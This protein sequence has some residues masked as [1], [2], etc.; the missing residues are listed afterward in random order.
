MCKLDFN[1]LAKKV[2]LNDSIIDPIVKSILFK[3]QLEN[4]ALAREQKKA[5]KENIANHIPATFKD[6]SECSV[7]LLEGL[8]HRQ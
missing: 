4:L 8:L 2:I 3:Q 5:K 6:R 1:S 7:F